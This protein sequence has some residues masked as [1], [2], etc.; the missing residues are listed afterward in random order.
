VIVSVAV[1]NNK[2]LPEA[3]VSVKPGWLNDPL[4]NVKI[5]GESFRVA[6]PPTGKISVV[7]AEGLNPQYA[8]QSCGPAASANKI[9]NTT[10]DIE[11]RRCAQRR[12]MVEDARRFWIREREI[13]RS[14]CVT[15][16]VV[17]TR[18][19]E[20][21]LSRARSVESAL[22]FIS[23]SRHCAISIDIAPSRHLAIS[24]SA[25][26]SLMADHS[27]YVVC[28]CSSDLS[29][30]ATTTKTTQHN[31]KRLAQRAL[32]QIQHQSFRS[33][34]STNHWCQRAYP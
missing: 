23:P 26:P 22:S 2:I 10:H 17:D 16:L 6:E 20:V 18:L 5:N 19:R 8:S 11:M 29:T 25:R 4:K 27:R 13:S 34:S 30:R 15:C 14:A 31:L 7:P 32:L 21:S 33:S 1:L 28:E 24:R 3:G 12:S 9:A